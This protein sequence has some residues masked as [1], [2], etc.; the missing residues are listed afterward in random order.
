MQVTDVLFLPICINYRPCDL[1]NA[2]VTSSVL[3]F[4]ILP[5]LCWVGYKIY[6]Q[7]HCDLPQHC[8]GIL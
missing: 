5:L 8:T 2:W 4:S 6:W 7:M 1:S 3:V